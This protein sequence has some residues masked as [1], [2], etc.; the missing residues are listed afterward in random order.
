LGEFFDKVF[1][2]WRKYCARFWRR[3]VIVLTFLVVVFIFFG[4]P[5]MRMMG[6]FLI[7]EDKITH[8]DAIFVLGGNNYDRSL[9]ALDLL[10]L[11]IA[12]VIYTLGEN[13]SND[14]MILGHE[15]PDALLSQEFLMDYGLTNSQVIPLVKGT[16]TAEESESILALCKEKGYSS[17]IV[18]S[19]KFHLRRISYVF[20]NKFAAQNIKVQLSGAP[21]SNYNE[22]VWWQFE[23]GL[24]MLN[25]EYIKLVYYALKGYN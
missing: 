16:S 1:H 3:F 21:N 17:I 19:D 15:I 5:I 7:A 11:G 9:K 8:A 25:N 6:D 4:K 23:S 24:I 12:P 14:L 22:N 18:V 10:Q 20:K 13:V 2:F